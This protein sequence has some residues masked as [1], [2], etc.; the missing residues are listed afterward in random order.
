MSSIYPELKEQLESLEDTIETWAMQHAVEAPAEVKSR[1]MERI[2]SVKQHR[3]EEE[4]ETPVVKIQPVKSHWRAIAAAC[5]VLAIGFGAMWFSNRNELS[6]V[7]SRYAEANEQLQEM[8]TENK[9]LLAE[10]KE[11]SNKAM[12]ET[13]RRQFIADP[14]TKAVT[15]K[16]T[17]GNEDAQ[18]RVFW[19]PEIAQASFVV[20]NLPQTS[21][22]LQYQL[23]AIVDGTPVDLG[24]F[25]LDVESSLAE[26]RSIDR[27]IPSS[28]A[29][30]ITLERRGGSPTPNLDALVVI[31]EV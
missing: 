16:G 24:V 5:V 18:V 30:A 29:F 15:L 27:S 23:W 22:E 19:N 31:G 14:N 6:D 7:Q 9:E 1:V 13:D 17:P 12:E 10:N 20:D 25:D 11:L 8:E 28:Q 26:I 3:S 21:E 4:S 2:A